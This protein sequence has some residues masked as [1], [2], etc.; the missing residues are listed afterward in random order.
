M[1]TDY[2][3]PYAFS[4]EDKMAAGTCGHDRNYGQEGPLKNGL[5]KMWNERKRPVNIAVAQAVSYWICELF[6]GK[7][8][9]F[10]RDKRLPLLSLQVKVL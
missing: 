9:C 8:S 10:I 2:S 3:K 5:H 7:L 6:S 4:M 1:E